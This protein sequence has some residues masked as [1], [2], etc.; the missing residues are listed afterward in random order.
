MGSGEEGV[1]IIH[2]VVRQDQWE[3]V[4]REKLEG[5]RELSMTIT[6][7]YSGRKNSQW[8]SLKAGVWLKGLKNK[9]RGGQCGW[10]GVNKNGSGRRWLLRSK[11]R[12]DCVG[13]ID[14]CKCL[15]F[16]F[17][18]MRNLCRIL[19]KGAAWA[20]LELGWSLCWEQILRARG[21]NKTSSEAIS[22]IQEYYDGTLK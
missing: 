6:A 3:N 11:G 1:A 2:T 18:E 8:D 15:A 4:T 21:R 14:H 9:K 22:V 20:N 5:V 16:I 12:Q 10:R 19:R 17:S 7:G 13:L